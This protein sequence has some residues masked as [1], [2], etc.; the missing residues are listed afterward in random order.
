ML[1]YVLLSQKYFYK[2]I[3]VTIF[4]CHKIVIFNYGID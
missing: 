4:F 3:N 1:D 2:E